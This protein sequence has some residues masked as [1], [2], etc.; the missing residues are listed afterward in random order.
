MI[1]H[2]NSTFRGD[3]PPLNYNEF[4]WLALITVTFKCIEREWHKSLPVN[5]EN[6]W[7]YQFNQKNEIYTG[8]QWTFGIQ[9]ILDTINAKY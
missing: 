1:T 7:N 6:L 5:S 8:M 9:A 3:V 2:N 4:E